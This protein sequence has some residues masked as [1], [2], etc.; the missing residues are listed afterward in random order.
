MRDL[1]RYLEAECPALAGRI[2]LLGY[3]RHDTTPEDV[4]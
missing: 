4:D 2:E 3:W 1:R